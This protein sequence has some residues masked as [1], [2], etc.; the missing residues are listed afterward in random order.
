VPIL[1]IVI[2][3]FVDSINAC[4]GPLADIWRSRWW[5]LSKEYAIQY[6]PSVMSS[7]SEKLPPYTVY[8]LIISLQVFCDPWSVGYSRLRG[9]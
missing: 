8:L 5:D 7:R 2:P 1:Q 3:T 4:H 6:N 9:Y